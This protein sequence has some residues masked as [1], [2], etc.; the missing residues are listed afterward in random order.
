M[1]ELEIKM[2]LV[3]F[4]LEQYE[5]FVLGSEYS[6]QFGERR[7]DLA[8][9]N[10]GELTAFEIKGS[11][12]KLS[13]LDYQIASYKN[14]FDY[15]FIVCE[16]SNLA[17]I[18]ASIPNEVGILLAHDNQIKHLRRSKH[19]KRHDKVMLASALSLNRLKELANKSQIRSKH[20]LCEHIATKYSVNLLRELS[21]LDFK[22]RYEVVTKMLRQETTTHLNPDDIHTITKKGPFPLK[23]RNN[24]QPQ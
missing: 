23:R 9:L 19:F 22:E 14:V 16:P 7:A 17:E 24:L 2:L 8:L 12:D 11:R 18:R 5:N 13:R 3:K 1:T 21:R 15:C 4:I 20:E 10:S 6:F